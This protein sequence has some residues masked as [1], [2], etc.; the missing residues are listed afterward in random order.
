MLFDIEADPRQQTPLD[1]VQTEQRMIALMRDAMA[2]CDAPVEQYE[3]LGL[4][5][6]SRT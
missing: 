1:D 5:E 4:D 3:R 2:E 6:P